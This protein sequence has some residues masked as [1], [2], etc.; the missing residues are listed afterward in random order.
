MIGREL[1][2]AAW[3]EESLGGGVGEGRRK[4]PAS[5]SSQFMVSGCPGACLC[6]LVSVRLTISFSMSVFS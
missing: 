6:L 3:R 5:L 2:G 1:N 4:G